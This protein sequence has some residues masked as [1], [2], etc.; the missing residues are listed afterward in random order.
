MKVVGNIICLHCRQREEGSL[1]LL[2]ISS[3]HFITKPLAVSCYS[4]TNYLAGA[5]EMPDVRDFIVETQFLKKC[6]K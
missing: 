3:K 6:C 1:T 5:K 4:L 2:K